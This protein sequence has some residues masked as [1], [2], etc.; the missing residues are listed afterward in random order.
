MSEPT[1]AGS[2]IGHY[3]IG[4]CLTS[5]TGGFSQLGVSVSSWR[6][7]TARPRLPPTPPCASLAV[8]CNVEIEAAG[9]TSMS[10]LSNLQGGLRI[11]RAAAA[12]A[13]NWAFHSSEPDDGGLL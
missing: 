4:E 10:A 7:W 3:A 2:P 9:D 12:V 1:V 6:L 11:N 8:A 5:I 13:D